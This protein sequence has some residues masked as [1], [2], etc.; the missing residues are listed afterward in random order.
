MTGGGKEARFRDVGDV[1][2]LA[3]RLQGIRYLLALC[4]VDERDH[5]AFGALVPGAIGQDAA[6][7]PDAV[8]R[9]DLT[10]DLR[11]VR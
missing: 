5:N 7:V 1:C 11:F 2:P 6:R 3:R 8:I 10:F 4:R 9:S